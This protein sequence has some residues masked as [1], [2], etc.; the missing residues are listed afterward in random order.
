MKHE[1]RHLKLNLTM[2]TKAFY[3]PMLIVIILQSTFS[4]YAM[5][6]NDMKENKY[7]K[8]ENEEVL[9]ADFDTEFIKSMDDTIQ[10]VSNMEKV[11]TEE[12]SKI[13]IHTVEKGESFWSICQKYYGSSDKYIKLR[14]YNGYTSGQ[15]LCVGAEIKVPVDQN[16]LNVKTISVATDDTKAEVQKVESKSAKYT[17]GVRTQPAVQIPTNGNMKNFT[18]EVDTSSYKL[19]GYYSTTGYDPKCSHCCGSTKGIGAAGVQIIPGYSV[20]APSNIPLGTTLYIEGYG[21]YVVED[22]GGFGNNNIDIACSNHETCGS[23]TNLSKNV[24]VYIV[25]NN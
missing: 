16:D 10:Y 1:K 17:Y 25:S 9:V 13:I 20:A 18:E 21:F 12:E 23:V 5:A 3:I 2:T 24:K 4:A 19:L 22:R 7:Q 11:D 14:D 8:S 6:F 15:N